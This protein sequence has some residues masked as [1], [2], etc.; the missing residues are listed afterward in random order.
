ML[1][2]FHSLAW[3]LHVTYTLAALTPRA[4]QGAARPTGFIA[5]PIR[6]EQAPPRAARPSNDCL[7]LRAMRLH[8]QRNTHHSL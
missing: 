5:T 2:A 6:G 4:T 1:A 7:S 8:K 3:L